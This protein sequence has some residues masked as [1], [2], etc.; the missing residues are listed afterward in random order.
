MTAEIQQQF[1]GI[2]IDIDSETEDGED[3]F[4]WINV[5]HGTRPEGLTAVVEQLAARQSRRTGF[6]IVPRIV[7]GGFRSG[8]QTRLRPRMFEAPRPLVF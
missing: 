5:P 1:P 4:L 3:A 2:R 7:S 6:W 8:P